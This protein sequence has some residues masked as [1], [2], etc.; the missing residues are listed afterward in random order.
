[1]ETNV[2]AP[3]RDALAGY[4]AFRLFR[5]HQRRGGVGPPIMNMNQW[6]VC[7][8]GAALF[9]ASWLDSTLILPGPSVGLLEHP[10]IFSFLLLQ[11]VALRVTETSLSNFL[12]TWAGNT[13]PFT[14]D[15]KG[16]IGNDI[17]D[18]YWESYLKRD[19]NIS[20]LLFSFFTMIGLISFAWNSYQNQEPLRFLGFDFWD[21]SFHFFGYWA[22][23]LYKFY[24]WTLFL[25]AVGHA[26]FGLFLVFAKLLSRARTENALVLRPYDGDSSG[27]V[28]ALTSP[29]VRP[30][31]AV[32]FV[33]GLGA[34]SALAIH[35]ELDLTPMIGLTLLAFFLSSGLLS[36][37]IP[38]SRAVQA[39]KRRQ[40]SEISERQGT[41]LKKIA[42]MHSTPAITSTVIAT[43]EALESVK[44]TIRSLPNCPGIPSVTG[45]FSLIL[46]SQYVAM[47][48]KFLAMKYLHDYLVP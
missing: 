28:T 4:P 13:L 7:I 46:G 22:T 39:E 29:L 48:L 43:I 12:T 30:I 16:S 15:F 41:L 14:E 1:M 35:R 33:C 2:L 6:T 20:K 45:V 11:L 18:G 37:L 38:L 26:L 32:F 31:S 42:D 36:Y 27:G 17:V 19:D 9:I 23:R 44:H 8:I 25:P 24:L 47:G 34:F 3:S 10:T 40:I 5:L 21:S